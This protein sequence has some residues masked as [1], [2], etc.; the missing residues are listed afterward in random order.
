MEVQS[1][2]LKH[3]SERVSSN[4]R[5][6]N[7][8]VCVWTLS[9][10][11]FCWTHIGPFPRLATMSIQQF[12]SVVVQL[13]LVNKGRVVYTLCMVKHWKRPWDLS[14]STGEFAWYPVSQHTPLS[15]GCLRVEIMITGWISILKFT[16]AG[17]CYES[18]SFHVIGMLWKTIVTVAHAWLIHE[19]WY[20]WRSWTNGE[21]VL[22][23]L[24]LKS[25]HPWS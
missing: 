21:Q 11:V 13:D 10:P 22:C 17:K 15:H 3:L 8:R 23:F 20:N 14:R 18:T 19:I 6:C 24:W 25:E 7:A 5:H 16:S 2:I 9:Q 4:L 12:L 1:M